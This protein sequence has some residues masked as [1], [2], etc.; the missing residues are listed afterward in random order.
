MVSTMALHRVTEALVDRGAHGL[1]AIE[2]LANAL[3][4]QH[5]RVD[6]DADGEHETGETGQREHGVE[7]GEHGERVQRRRAR[8]P[9]RR[10]C[11]RSGSRPIM[12]TTISRTAITTRVMPLWIESCAEARADLAHLGD[13]ERHRQRAGPEHEREVL[14]RLQRAAA[15]A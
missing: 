14:R 9:R 3:E 2:L 12:I 5:V 8:A 4:D 15:H 11:R 6:R 7:A 13:L 1:A 10:A